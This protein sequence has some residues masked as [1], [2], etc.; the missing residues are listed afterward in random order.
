MASRIK[1]FKP[2]A[3]DRT[4]TTA[5]IGAYDFRAGIAA[6]L[7]RSALGTIRN[8]VIPAGEST[9][10][11]GIA[12]SG[13]IFA[14]S[15]N[16]MRVVYNRFSFVVGAAD[17]TA[18]IGGI[19]SDGTLDIAASH[20]SLGRIDLFV[21]RI[22]DDENSLGAERESYLEIITGTASGSPVAPT[23]PAGALEIARVQ[24]DAGVTAI[25]PAKITFPNFTYT[26]AVGGIR[27]V[28]NAVSI[29]A[30]D[31]AGAYRDNLGVLERNMGKNSDG[32]PRGWVAV[33]ASEWIAWTPQ[34]KSTVRTCNLG[35]GGS[36]NGEY[37]LTDRTCKFRVEFHMGTSGVDGGA[38]DVYVDFP[39]GVNGRQ[40]GRGLCQAY[41]I[42]AAG[43][44]Q[45]FALIYPDVRRFYPEFPINGTVNV[46]PTG[47]LRNALS[48]GTVDCIPHQPAGFFAV[49][50]NNYLILQ[51]EFPLV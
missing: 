45:G 21:G 4:S 15:P 6:L 44:M 50:K 28:G 49:D 27:P 16:A 22:Y 38:G 1:G 8:G 17:S 32:S 30:S 47:R 41:L 43:T 29:A 34:L 23:L 11:P 36:V 10:F 14:D 18:Y 19:T 46:V 51:G 26:T 42:S 37:Q 31:Y 12:Q 25:T 9:A 5:G 13:L 48:N 39:T 7:N 40:S 3:V 35:V 2:I 24:V 20:A 33:G